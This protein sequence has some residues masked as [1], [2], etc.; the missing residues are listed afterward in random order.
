MNTLWRTIVFAA[1]LVSL[2]VGPMFA[3]G[4]R[5]DWTISGGQGGGFFTGAFAVTGG[6]HLRGSFSGTDSNGCHFVG[7]FRG[8]YSGTSIAFSI[9]KVSACFTSGTG[10]GTATAPYPNDPVG[11]TAAGTAMCFG[12]ALCQNPAPWT[13]TRAR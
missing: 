12:S 8:T 3:A 6:G 4:A 5:Q 7:T 2:P 10:S 13:A 9:T 11:T 1:L